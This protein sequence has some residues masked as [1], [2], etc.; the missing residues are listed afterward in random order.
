MMPV[1]KTTFP[2]YSFSLFRNQF[3]DPEHPKLLQAM[4]QTSL[5]AVSCIFVYPEVHQ[6]WHFFFHVSSESV[7]FFFGGGGISV[8]PFNQLRYS[9][10]WWAPRDGY[11][12][13]SVWYSSWASWD[14]S[15]YFLAWCG[16]V[17]R[18]AGAPPRGAGSRSRKIRS[19]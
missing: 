9:W 19:L 5:A 11:P 18:G 10:T 13:S 15:P 3:V 6:G 1:Y 2:C 7:C 8:H 4:P 12:Y 16:E 17:R 14:H